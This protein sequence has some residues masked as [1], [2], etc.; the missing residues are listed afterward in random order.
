MSRCAASLTKD[1]TP[2]LFSQRLHLFRIV[3]GAEPFGKLEEGAFFLLAGCDPLLDKFH[4][5]AI[6]AKPPAFRYGVHLRGDLPRQRHAPAD[7]SSNLFCR[8]HGTNIHHFGA[9]CPPLV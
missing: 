8:W 4:E 9:E 1:E 2:E 6:I 5:D 7:M 3:R